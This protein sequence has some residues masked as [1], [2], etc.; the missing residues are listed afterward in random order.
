MSLST[1][2]RPAAALEPDW[3]IRRELAKL[4]GK[5][6]NSISRIRTTDDW[7]ISVIDVTMAIT[8]KNAQA[9]AK[10]VSSMSEK[11]PEVCQKLIH[12]RFRGP[13]QRDTPVAA[14]AVMVEILML[15]PGSTAAAVR[16]EA[17]KLLVRYLGGDLKLVDEVRALRHIQEELADAAPLHPLRTFGKA[18]EAGSSSGSELSAEAVKAMISEVVKDMNLVSKADLT[19]A[20][21][22]RSINHQVEHR[23]TR[24]R[25][26]TGD[27]DKVF[28][29]GPG[30]SR[31][32]GHWRNSLPEEQ[33]EENQKRLEVEAA[34]QWPSLDQDLA[35]LR[36]LRE[37]EAAEKK[38]SRKRK[39]QNQPG[40]ADIDDQ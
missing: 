31:P 6:V 12:F 3:E 36:A 15:L 37:R 38:R 27:N 21:A 24:K 23:L 17:S 32:L 8:G 20:R 18:V 19:A 40:R 14:L 11:Y 16:V 4:L 5:D 25:G 35:D 28:L 7:E 2:K 10:D 39:A 29:L 13:G 1:M 33:K 30:A 34:A 26:L 9:A 22:M